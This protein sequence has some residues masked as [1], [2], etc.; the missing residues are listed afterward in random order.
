MEVLGESLPKEMARV[1]ELIIQY[2]DPM[3]NGCGRMAAAMMENSLREAD[4][5]A[6]SGDLVAMINAYNDL[7]D[8]S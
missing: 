8:Y 4:K 5:A 3:L 1:R 7:K 2:N 6:M